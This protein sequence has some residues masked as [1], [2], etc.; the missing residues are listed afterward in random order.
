M[1]SALDSTCHAETLFGHNAI[2]EPAVAEPVVVVRICAPSE[3]P[4][5]VYF[6]AARDQ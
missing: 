3:P 5:I 2:A 6:S 1:A 4:C